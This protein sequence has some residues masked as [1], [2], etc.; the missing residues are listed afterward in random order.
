MRMKVIAFMWLIAAL[1]TL[2][3]VGATARNYPG[4]TIMSKRSVISVMTERTDKTRELSEAVREFVL[5]WG[6]LG[7]RWGVN[8]SVSQIHALLYASERALTAEEIADALSI[9][10]SNVSTSLRELQNWDIV[11][12][13]S[14]MGDRRTFFEAETDLWTLMARIAAGRK[15]RELDPAAAALKQCLTLAERDGSVGAI[16]T[17]RLRAMLEF[18]EQTGRW[19]DQMA[20]LPKSQ[21]AKLMK[22]GSGVSRWLLPGRGKAPGG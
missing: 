5:L 11:R 15:A 14:V 9:A 3:P 10:R 7:E 20:T 8:R 4:L 19:Y 18:V 6:N 17:K 2:L 22:L 12:P 16:S 21:L 13:V 1:L